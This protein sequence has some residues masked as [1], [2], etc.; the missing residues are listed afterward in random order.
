M[1]ELLFSFSCHFIVFTIIRHPLTKDVD[2]V[3]PL[4]L[5][6]VYK[7]IY[8]KFPKFQK[9]LRFGE[10]VLRVRGGQARLGG[11]LQVLLAPTRLLACW[12]QAWHSICFLPTLCPRQA[13]CFIWYK[14]LVHRDTW[15]G[16]YRLRPSIS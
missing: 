11:S 8:L 1:S 14:V 7:F 12:P 16:V 5:P 13:S 15:C 2:E 4:D 3:F 6:Y 10:A 9:W